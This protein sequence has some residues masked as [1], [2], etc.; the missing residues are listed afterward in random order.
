M[1]K[2]L[3]TFGGG[4]SSGGKAGGGGGKGGGGGGRPGK[5][6]GGGGKGAAKG[7]GATAK[8]SRTKAAAGKPG[9]G[10]LQR[11]VNGVKRVGSAANRAMGHAAGFISRR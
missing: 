8:L 11:I 6:F 5:G 2:F 9:P 10:L 3:E 1:R 4:S 7:G